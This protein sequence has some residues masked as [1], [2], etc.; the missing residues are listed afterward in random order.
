MKQVDPKTGHETDKSISCKDFYD[1]HFMV[2]EEFDH[3]LRFVQVGWQL[4]VEAYAK[5]EVEWFLFYQEESRKP[6]G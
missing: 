1:F 3:I 5:M 4:I 6:E 2:H